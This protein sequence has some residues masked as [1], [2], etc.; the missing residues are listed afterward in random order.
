MSVISTV[1]MFFDISCE[2]IL[3]PI[4][5]PRGEGHDLPVRVAGALLDVSGVPLWTVW[6][7]GNAPHFA[8][9]TQA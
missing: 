8:C 7:G 3:C 2:T 1:G 6:S 5:R 9:H 4:P